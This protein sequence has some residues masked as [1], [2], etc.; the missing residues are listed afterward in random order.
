MGHFVMCGWNE[1]VYVPWFK[2]E[3]CVLSGPFVETTS[4]TLT[5]TEHRATKDCTVATIYC[6]RLA[7]DVTTARTSQQIIGCKGVSLG[8]VLGNIILD[9]SSRIH[10]N[11]V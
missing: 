11:V 5:S 8:R 10:Q 3:T 1:C 6:I 9:P 4:V 2:E 7:M